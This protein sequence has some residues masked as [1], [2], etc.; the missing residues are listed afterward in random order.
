[1]ASPD[2]KYKTKHRGTEHCNMNFHK[3]GKQKQEG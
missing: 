1:M 2:K 3:G